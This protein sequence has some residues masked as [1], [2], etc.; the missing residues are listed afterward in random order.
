MISD[1]VH[2]ASDVFGTF[3]VMIGVTVADKKSDKEHPYGHERLECVASILLAVIL[4]LI[5]LGIG[6][7]G[8]QKIIHRDK[9]T[10]VVPG[11]LALIAA[12]LSIIVKEW[13]YWYTRAAAKKINFRGTYGRGLASQIRCALLGRRIHRHTWRQAG[14]TH[15]GSH[16]QRGNLYLY[17]KGRSR[18]LQR[19]HG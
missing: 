4:M 19:C 9:G 16:C 5:G 8:I 15:S 14:G 13:M 7:G 18:H 6:I 10:L 2:S 12:V 11:V 1:A 17:R 3:I